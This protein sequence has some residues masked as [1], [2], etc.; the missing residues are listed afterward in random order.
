MQINIAQLDR[1]SDSNGVVTVHWTAF[2]TEGDYTASSYG[3]QSFQP[4]PE[5]EGFVPFEELTEETVV[6]WLTSQ[7]NCSSDLEARL[8]ADIENQK[9]PPI[10]HGL[11]W[12]STE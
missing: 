6:G 4:D 7:E 3:A 12:T 10:L 2:K 5:S 1:K 11:P 9:N 8:D